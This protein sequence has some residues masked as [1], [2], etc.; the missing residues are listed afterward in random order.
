LGIAY[1]EVLETIARV[2]C[3]PE[4]LDSTVDNLWN[5]AVAKQFQRAVSHPLNRRFGSPE[6][7][8]GYHVARASV[9][10]RAHE[11]AGSGTCKSNRHSA[12]SGVSSVRE[13]TFAVSDGRLVGRPDVVRGSEIL[14]YKTGDIFEDGENASEPELKSS[15]VRQ[16]RLYAFIAGSALSIPIRRGTL[17]PLT[18]Q[19]V[20][21]ELDESSCRDEAQAALA[22]LDLYNERVSV[23]VSPEDLAAPSPD[24]CSFCPFQVICPALWKTV[25]DTWFGKLD[26]ELLRGAVAEDLK[27]LMGGRAF[28][29]A[30]VTQNGTLKPGRLELFPLALDMHH[31]LSTV[32]AGDWIRI[33]GLSRRLDGTV[34]PSNRTVTIKESKVPRIKTDPAD[35]GGARSAAPTGR[36]GHTDANS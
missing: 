10:L 16:L 24:A 32:K 19:P 15:Y 5:H 17:V 34:F 30:V 29:L 7:W 36:P 31:D 3:E 11:I 27:Q 4:L 28:A 1:H 23:G 8:P 20:E 2:S 6:T 25:N 13:K 9:H 14:D 33:T 21:V 12:A 18:G 26:G 35:K 22:R